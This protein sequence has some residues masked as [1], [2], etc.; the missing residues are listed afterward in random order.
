MNEFIMEILGYLKIIGG[1]LLVIVVVYLC[2]NGGW[3][4][5]KF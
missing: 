3:S 1:I 5:S 2:F 4:L